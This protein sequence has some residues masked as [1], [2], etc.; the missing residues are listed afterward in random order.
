[1]SSPLRKKKKEKIKIKKYTEREKW[2][3]RKEIG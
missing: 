2:V 1:M 3:I